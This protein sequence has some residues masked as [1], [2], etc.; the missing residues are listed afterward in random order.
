MLVVVGANIECQ[1]CNLTYIEKL[2]WNVGYTLRL[3]CMLALFGET[4]FLKYKYD[5]TTSDNINSFIVYKLVTNI[6]K[7]SSDKIN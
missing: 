4:I 7:Y 2:T 1:L 6:L 5:K 3:H